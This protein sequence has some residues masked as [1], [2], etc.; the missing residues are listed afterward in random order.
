MPAPARHPVAEAPTVRPPRLLDDAELAEVAEIDEL[1][2]VDELEGEGGE[3]Q[4]SPRADA[5][6]VAPLA[7]TTSSGLPR[8]VRQASLVAQL[9]E[10]P[11]RP[12]SASDPGGRDPEEIRAM[13]GSYRRDTLRGRLHAEQS[14]EGSAPLES[15]ADHGAGQRPQGS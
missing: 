9:R 7:P 10:Q 13:I 3:G 14:M 2:E 8:R 1:A 6:P 4:S 11:G 12:P 15:L 5:S